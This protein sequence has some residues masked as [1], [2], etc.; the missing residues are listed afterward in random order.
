MMVAAPAGKT[1]LITG[2]AGQDGTLLTD[3][4]V[5]L[6]Y[7][8]VG[9]VRRGYSIQPSS[10]SGPAQLTEAD[11]CDPVALREL[12]S[13]F[14]PSEIYHFAALHHSTQES[15]RY[16]S[17]QS[18]QRMVEINFESTKALAF[19]LLELQLP[20][21][22]VFAAS[23]QMYTADDFQDLIDETSPKKPRTFYGHTKSWGVDLLALLRNEFGL[24]ASSAILFNHESHLRGPQYVSRKIALAASAAH[25]GRP[26]LLDLLNIGARA[27]WSSATD[28][29][30]A[31]HLIA[32]SAEPRDYVVAS[33]ELRTVRDMLHIAFGHVG[34]DWRKFTTFRFDLDEHALC[35]NPKLLEETLGWKRTQSFQETIVEMVNADIARAQSRI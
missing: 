3:H 33:G 6:G 22:L 26:V 34:L 11:I 28:V 35:G 23:S 8:V 17:F 1:A 14:R 15:S 10:Q 25:L 20:S 18:R 7:K 32:T 24:C 12:L 21:H 27:D 30:H 2:A 4:L 29:V 16:S 5:R 19:T 9:V 31:L 13:R